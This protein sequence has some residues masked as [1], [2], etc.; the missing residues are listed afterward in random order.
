MTKKFDNFAQEKLK[1][2]IKFST[3]NNKKYNYLLSGL[4]R[5]KTCGYSIYGKPTSNSK[6]KRLYYRCMGQDAHR[7][8]DGRVCNGHPVRVEALDEL[9]WDS[10]KTLLLEPEIIINE[11]QRRLNSYKT[12]YESIIS[13]KNNE[14]NRY[15][16]ER[17]RLIDLF[18]SGIVEQRRNRN[19]I[20]RSSI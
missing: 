12:D 3:R 17:A 18:Q 7:W 9:V 1:N 4:L 13:Q 16:K 5:C 10:V 8:P 14:I 15:K 6:Y 19:K 20:E 11:Y 2:N